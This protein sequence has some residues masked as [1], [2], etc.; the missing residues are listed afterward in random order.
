VELI[1]EITIESRYNQDY[2]KGS[3]P[4]IKG[5]PRRFTL[6]RSSQAMK[7][8]KQFKGT[9]KTWKQNVR[10]H[11]RMSMMMRMLLMLRIKTS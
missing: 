9:M 2:S 10:S 8:M 3:P 1:G 6:R 4:R 7:R 11:I 5:L